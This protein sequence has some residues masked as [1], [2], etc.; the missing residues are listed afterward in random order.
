[1]GDTDM[2][3]AKANWRSGCFV[4]KILYLF[5]AT[6][7]LFQLGESGTVIPRSD[8]QSYVSLHVL[9]NSRNPTPSL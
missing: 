4:A 9:V 1:M 3:C 7:L 2:H 5:S 8:V 6:D